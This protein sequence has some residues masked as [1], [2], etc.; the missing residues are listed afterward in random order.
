MVNGHPIEGES[1]N[2]A[3][4]DVYLR[5]FVTHGDWPA[6]ATVAL[7]TKKRQL[8]F[9][10]WQKSPVERHLFR[11]SL[12]GGEPE[13]LTRDPGTHGARDGRGPLRGRRRGRRR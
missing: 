1:F 8:Y 2:A 13:Q 4:R 12:D 11:V 7:D 9:V 10:G 6:E 5:Y 3:K